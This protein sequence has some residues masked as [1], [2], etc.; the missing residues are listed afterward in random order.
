MQRRESKSNQPTIPSSQH[1]HQRTLGNNQD[2]ENT[3]Q[4]SPPLF[5]YSSACSQVNAQKAASLLVPQR[6]LYLLAGKIQAE[7]QCD[8]PHLPGAARRWAWSNIHIQQ[9]TSV[10]AAGATGMGGQLQGLPVSLAAARTP[11][12]CCL[13]PAGTSAQ[14]CSRCAQTSPSWDE[15]LRRG[16]VFCNPLKQGLSVPKMHRS[17]SEQL[18]HSHFTAPLEEASQ[19][20]HSCWADCTCQTCSFCQGL[21]GD[22][23]GRVKSLG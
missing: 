18:C 12:V 15:R 5:M 7:T 2:G 11:A 17:S 13:C 14:S 3:G 16:L 20:S 1:E 21:K 10:L 9:L 4:I 6:N 19:P 22:R 8:I 23:L